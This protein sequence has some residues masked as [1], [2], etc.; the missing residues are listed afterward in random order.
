MDSLQEILLS[1]ISLLKKRR[2][3]E[4]CNAVESNGAVCYKKR[5]KNDKYCS[6]HRGRLSK[7]KSFDLPKK[8]TKKCKFFECN[9]KF[10]GK[11]YCKYHYAIH[12]FIPKNILKKCSVENCSNKRN[13]SQYVCAMHQI[14]KYRY[15]SLDGNGVNNVEKMREGLKNWLKQNG[16]QTKDKY[17]IEECIAPTC[18]IKNSSSSPLRKGLCQNHYRRWK[19]W[20]DYN[21]PSKKE[22]LTAL[23]KKY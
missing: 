11:N 8:K 23:L 20:G 16:H 9:R 6:N 1:E 15:G 18:N 5:A 10:Y 4:L 19:K 22:Y 2:D 14:R 3:S 21:I 12:I 13:G 17:K 7:Y